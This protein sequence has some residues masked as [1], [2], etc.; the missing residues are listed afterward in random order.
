[1]SV[2]KVIALPLAVLFVNVVN[3]KTLNLTQE[4]TVHTAVELNNQSSIVKKEKIIH[5]N[6]EILTTNLLALDKLKIQLFDGIQVIVNK[7]HVVDNGAS[8]SFQPSEISGTQVSSLWMGAVDSE[9]NSKVVLAISPESVSGKIE[10][11]GRTFFIRYLEGQQLIREMKQGTTNVAK[12][13]DETRKQAVFKLV[14][15]ER[16]ARNLHKY[17][18][19]SKLAKSSRLH[20]EDMAQNNYFSHTSRDGRSPFERMKA[21]GYQHG[22]AAENI[23]AGSSNA[24]GTMEQWMNSSGHRA[25]ILSKNY[26]D[27]GVG[28]AY[29]SNNRYRHLWTQNFGKLRGTNTCQSKPDPDPIPNPDPTPNP[30]PGNNKFKP[31]KNKLNVCLGTTSNSSANGARIN[32]S[33]CS[34][35]KSQ[36]WE[37]DSKGLLHPA[38]A[39]DK[40]LQM[41]Q[42]WKGTNRA[43]IGQ[44]NAQQLNQRWQLVDGRIQNLAYRMVYLKHFTKYGDWVGIWTKDDS[45]GQQWQ[46]K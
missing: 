36:Q 19:D 42:W 44:C 24:E 26:C 27:I 13:L 7:K 4:N 39:P 20:S 22:Y 32:A 46:F 30:D 11:M 17:N 31:V 38:N 35:S 3:A 23:A 12:M 10:I 28:Y 25:S 8:T 16:A 2:S 43:V 41:P 9:P 1:M 34:N 40:C 29:S 5:I 33:R 37:L 15:Q 6:P 45:K 18:Y 21:Q 14:N